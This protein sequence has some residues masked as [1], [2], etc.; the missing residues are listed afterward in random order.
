MF[1]R[2]PIER[3]AIL[4]D[5]QRAAA[6]PTAMFDPESLRARG[7]LREEAGG[8]GS[9]VYFDGD[10]VHWVYRRYLRGGMAAQIARD[11]FLWL[12]EER[13][14][15]FRELRLLGELERRGLPVPVPVAARY[16]RGLVSY[17]AELVT[18]CL[19]DA[20]SMAAVFAAGGM[21]DA[22]W[23]DVG[24][25]LRRFHDAGVQHADLNARN[26]MLGAQ[27][28]VWVLD[29][30]RGRLRQPGAWRERVLDRL[31]RSLVKIGDH[32]TGWQAGFALLRLAH[33]A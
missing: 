16:R 20:R 21:D 11:R 30:D 19:P 31:E 14:R 28:E 7:T 10:G 32:V 24:R 33:D 27:G 18:E 29:F 1:E 8:R 4:F 3:G 23:A 17:C 12:G 13:T 25:C 6:P 2:Q 5:P 26:I 9:I 22:R 15:S